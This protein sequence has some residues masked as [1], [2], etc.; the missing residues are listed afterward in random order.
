MSFHNVA[1]RSLESGGKLRV[2]SALNPILWL[3]GII[4][5]PSLLFLKVVWP[6]PTWLI[7]VILTLVF[8]PVITA[9]GAFLFFMF[10]D[11]DKLQSEEYQ[12]LKREL[13]IIEQKGDLKPLILTAENLDQ[14]PTPITPE[15]TEGDDL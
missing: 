13:E 4:A 8:I 12:L 3:C 11:P 10:K 1:K 9:I 5:V 15:T 2:K 14:L 7:I 6:P